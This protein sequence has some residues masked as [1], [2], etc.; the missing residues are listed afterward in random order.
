MRKLFLP[1]ALFLVLT[2]A[3]PAPALAATPKISSPSYIL[4]DAAT[5]QI[6]LQQSANEKAYPASVTKVATALVVL[7]RLQMDQKIT[8][9]KEARV[10]G[11]RIFL[12][13]GSQM[14]VEDA[15]YALMLSSANDAAVTLAVAVSGSVEAFAQEMNKAAQEAGATGTHFVNPH[16]LPNDNHYTTARDLALVTKQAL[17]IEA[18]RKVVMT[19]NRDV[20]IT[21]DGVRVEKLT[22]HNRL[23]WTYEGCTGVKTGFTNQ[24]KHTQI[25]SARRGDRE[26]IAVALGASSA[27]AVQRD[28]TSL[29]TYGFNTYKPKQVVSAGQPFGEVDMVGGKG[30]AAVVALA[31]LSVLEGEGAPDTTIR[32]IMQKEL[33]APVKAG[34]KVGKAILMQGE[35]SLGQVDLVVKEDV[36]K[37]PALPAPVTKTGMMAIPLAAAL[38]ILALAITRRAGRRSRRPEDMNWRERREWRRRNGAL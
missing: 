2:V 15:L 14:T 25:A 24:S 16:G 32:I 28:V 6:L 23:L 3:I 5:G 31:S 7:A 20:R 19:Q 18:F 12:S 21:G 9:P 36:D 11:S 10:G 17:S 22:N 33:K 37:A 1:I 26:F 38:S 8:V 29:L 35:R 30:N 27:A 13:T 4:M 34:T